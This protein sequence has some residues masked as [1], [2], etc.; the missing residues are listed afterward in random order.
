MQALLNIGFRSLLVRTL[1]LTIGFRRTFRSGTAY[2]RVQHG[3]GTPSY[4]LTSQALAVPRIRVST[5]G[6]GDAY[7]TTGIR[8]ASAL[9]VLSLSNIVWERDDLGGGL[10]GGNDDQGGGVGGDHSGEDGG[11]DDEEVVCSVDLGVEI[12]NGGAAVAAVVAADLGGSDPVVGAA[13]AGG[14]DHLLLC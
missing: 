13:V 5:G 6:T 14:D 8:L 4:S 10:F 1:L 7:E 2:S 3:M 12:Y 11:V 9:C